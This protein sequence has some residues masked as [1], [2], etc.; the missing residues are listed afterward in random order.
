MQLRPIPSLKGKEG[1]VEFDRAGAL[2][3]AHSRKERTQCAPVLHFLLLA[4]YF[5]HH[6]RSKISAVK[7]SRTSTWPIAASLA[8]A[9]LALA[10]CGSDAIDT[11]TPQKA[12]DAISVMIEQGHPE[13]LP[14]MLEIP[15]RD[16]TFADG[17]TEASAIGDVKDKA[18]DMLAQLWRV[19][20]KIKARFGKELEK[21]GNA[22]LEI[23]AREGFDYRSLA[24]Q[25]LGDPLGFLVANRAR[26][27]AEDM[28]DGTAAVLFDGEPALGGMVSLVETDE[29]WRVQVPVDVLRSNKYWPDTRHE[30]SVVAS[31]MLGIENSLTDFET[32]F[33]EGKIRSLREAGERVGRLVGESVVVQ[34][35]IYAMMKR[36]DGADPK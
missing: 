28:G 5:D 7:T 16:V 1:L 32:E 17:V 34:S 35:V 3:L 6:C 15:A 8:V 4:I 20:G 30:W 33:D 2:N 13:G 31:M 19:S 27:T 24:R 21:E 22:G 25:V 9:L 23:A 10:G 14:Q 29:G 12:L 26:L 18:G 36:D 11:S